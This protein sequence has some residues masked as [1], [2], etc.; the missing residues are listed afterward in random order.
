MTKFPRD[1]AG[2]LALAKKMSDD[3]TANP[4]IYPAPPASAEALD[5]SLEACAAAKD[6]V[7]GIK[8]ALEAA[9]RL[10]QAAFA[11]LEENMHDNIRYAENAVHDDD[12]K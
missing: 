6:A 4:D 12:A 9:V 11:R 5:A 2:I 8:A 1:E 10:K 7:Q 3:F